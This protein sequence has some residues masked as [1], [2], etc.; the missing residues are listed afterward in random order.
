MVFFSYQRKILIKGVIELVSP[1]TKSEAETR[2]EIDNRLESAD[3][4]ALD[5]LRSVKEVLAAT[6]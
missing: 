6:E 1:D 5:E 2:Q 3:W 4:E